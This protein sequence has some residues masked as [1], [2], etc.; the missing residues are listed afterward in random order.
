MLQ[1]GQDDNWCLTASD[2]KS[3]WHEIMLD[4]DSKPSKTVNRAWLTSCMTPNQAW[5]ENVRAEE[6]TWRLWL[7]C[8]NRV[9]FQIQHDI[10]SFPWRQSWCVIWNH[11][12]VSEPTPP[13]MTQI[14]NAWRPEIVATL[15]WIFTAWHQIMHS[16]SVRSENHEP[17]R[18]RCTR[19]LPFATVCVCT[20]DERA[21]LELKFVR[22]RPEIELKNWRLHCHVRLEIV[23]SCLDE[24][25]SPTFKV[26]NAILKCNQQRETT[27]RNRGGTI[28]SE[29]VNARGGHDLKSCM[30]GNRVRLQIEHDVKSCDM[31]SCV[32][33]NRTWYILTTWNRSVQNTVC[34]RLCGY[35][36]LSLPSI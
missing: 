10:K 30:T 8:A 29:S 23:S 12:D 5:R 24:S 22:V 9:R 14:N 28:Y 27:T 13:S 11:T 3:T 35:H 33:A 15:N 6:Q 7:H 4:S 32:T 20:D 1:I 17:L 36:H 21:P 31:K 16:S 26:K 19:L 34:V 25:T 18:G 2:W